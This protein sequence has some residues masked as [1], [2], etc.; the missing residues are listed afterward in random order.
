MQSEGEYP[1]VIILEM[2]L[3]LA[4]NFANGAIKYIL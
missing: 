3:V 1:G 4:P 2:Q